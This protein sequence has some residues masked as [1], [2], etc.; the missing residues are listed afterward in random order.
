MG[1]SNTVATLPGILSPLLTGAI[2]QDQVSMKFTKATIEIL[3]TREAFI[4]WG[5]FDTYLS[6][7]GRQ[8]IAFC[9]S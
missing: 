4:F 6:C 2:V 1:I 8:A 5:D 9:Y 7:F 3:N